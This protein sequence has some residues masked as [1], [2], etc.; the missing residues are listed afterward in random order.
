MTT[1]ASHLPCTP[2]LFVENS[3][4][5]T[6]NVQKLTSRQCR[7]RARSN[8]V[9]TQCFAKPGRAKIRCAECAVIYQLNT[10][11][12]PLTGWKKV[13]KDKSSPKLKTLGGGCYRSYAVVLCIPADS[14]K[15]AL[16]HGNGQ[17]ALTQLAHLVDTQDSRSRFIAVA[18]GVWG[19][20]T[21]IALQRCE[22]RPRGW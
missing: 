21:D 18:E 2:M 14:A 22:E 15:A 5:V 12:E 16:R 20:S 6:Q 11:T 7:R 19:G 10:V 9:P 4:L 17:T 3:P 13:R 1:R 8:V